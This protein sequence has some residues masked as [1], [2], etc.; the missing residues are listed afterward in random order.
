MLLPHTLDL[1]RACTESPLRRQRVGIDQESWRVLLRSAIIASKL[2]LSLAVFH[3]IEL[4]E[5]CP[6]RGNERAFH[7]ACA[8]QCS[9]H[10]Q[11]RYARYQIVED[12]RQAKGTNHI[13]STCSV[14]A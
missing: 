7:V 10:R 12:T 5:G 8:W 11:S 1:L 3:R 4:H 13:A 2:E 9:M 14:K 6:C